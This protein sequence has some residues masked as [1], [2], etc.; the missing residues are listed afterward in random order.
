MACANGSRHR[1]SLSVRDILFDAAQENK[2]ALSVS[3]QHI[4]KAHVAVA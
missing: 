2:A 4:S 1:K 3:G